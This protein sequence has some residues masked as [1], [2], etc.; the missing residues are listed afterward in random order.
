MSQGSSKPQT[1][2]PQQQKP[3]TP[4]PPPPPT[5]MVNDGMPPGLRPTKKG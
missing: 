3:Q 4:P 1:P 2:K 5:R